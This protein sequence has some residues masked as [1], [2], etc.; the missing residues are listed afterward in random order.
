MQLVLEVVLK[1]TEED[2]VVFSVVVDI[3]VSFVSD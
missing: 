3:F 1:K 2:L